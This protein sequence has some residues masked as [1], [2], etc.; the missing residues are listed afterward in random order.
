MKEDKSNYSSEKAYMRDTIEVFHSR[1]LKDVDHIDFF[2][3]VS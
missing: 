2:Y 1:L 3:E